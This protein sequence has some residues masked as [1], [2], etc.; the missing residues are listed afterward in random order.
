MGT[1][2]NNPVAR[3]AR[4]SSLL[5]CLEVLTASP[6]TDNNN[7]GKSLNIKAILLVTCLLPLLEDYGSFMLCDGK[8]P[9]YVFNLK[10]R[11]SMQQRL[12]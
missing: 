10:P 7:H 8:S 1:P 11:P 9:G 6:K 4:P 3:A 5:A 12:N 2:L